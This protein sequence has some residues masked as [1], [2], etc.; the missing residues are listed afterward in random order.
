MD[1]SAFSTPCVLT[2]EEHYCS[3]STLVVVPGTDYSPT[4]IGHSW[5]NLGVGTVES[6][7]LVVLLAGTEAAGTEATGTEAVGTT[8]PSI[9]SGFAAW[10]AM[11]CFL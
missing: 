2:V 9:S 1:S 5:G 11:P 10:T 4:P 8:G 6:A 7:T 3:S